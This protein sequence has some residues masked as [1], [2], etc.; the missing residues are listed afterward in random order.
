MSGAAHTLLPPA[1][2]H[3]HGPSSLLARALG[4]DTKGK[5]PLVGDTSA[6]ALSFG[7]EWLSIALYV[8]VARMWR[9]PNTRIHRA[10]GAR[11]G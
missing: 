11:S 7:N 10:I 2:P 6:I 8:A 3:A 5:R 1:I 4:S 9:V